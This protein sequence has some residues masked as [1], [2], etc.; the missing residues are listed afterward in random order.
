[1]RW[2]QIG[3][4]AIIGLL[5]CGCYSST[6]VML[7][8]PDRNPQE[9]A[10]P[11]DSE[12]AALEDTLSAEAEIKLGRVGSMPPGE[13]AEQPGGGWIYQ[14]TESGG[15]RIK[16]IFYDGGKELSL[17]GYMREGNT[18]H[19]LK[20]GNYSYSIGEIE[21]DRIDS[22]EVLQRYFKTAR[23][24]IV[25]AACV[26]AVGVVVYIIEADKEMRELR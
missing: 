2:A 3:L 25:A 24:V 1:M 5:G 4:A 16:R 8:N 9:Q 20:A 12:W 14:M 11:L 15:S 7:R 22:V 26:F 17:S 6:A 23:P 10:M 18:L 13:V 19:L 21:I